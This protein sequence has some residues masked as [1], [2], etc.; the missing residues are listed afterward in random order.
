LANLIAGAQTRGNES[1]A[2]PNGDKPPLS[3]AFSLPG[4]A[5]LAH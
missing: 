1:F 3:I 2:G 5:K 4:F